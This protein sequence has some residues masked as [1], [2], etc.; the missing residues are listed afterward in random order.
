[1][2]ENILKEFY[3]GRKFFLEPVDFENINEISG[4]IE[5]LKKEFTEKKF[6]I[7]LLETEFKIDKIQLDVCGNYL[8]ITCNQP[9]Y[10][11]Q[12]VFTPYREFDIKLSDVKNIDFIIC[13]ENDT[14]HAKIAEFKFLL[15]KNDNLKT[16]HNLYYKILI[17]QK[18]KEL[19][20][21]KTKLSTINN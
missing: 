14:R 5:L 12:T 9:I 16:Y 2:N 6:P 3:I 10:F 7:E 1:M 15:D 13:D 21:L 4:N 19:E 20:N 18:E 17:S 8:R 11:G